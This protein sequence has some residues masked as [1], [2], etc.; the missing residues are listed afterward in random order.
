MVLEFMRGCLRQQDREGIRVFL[1]HSGGAPVATPIVEERL[2]F[3]QERLPPNELPNH[4][5][6]MP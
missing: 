3:A 5:D 2:G 1:R 6:S 4:Y